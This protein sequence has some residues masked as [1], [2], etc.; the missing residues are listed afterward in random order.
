MGLI[1]PPEKCHIT[2]MPTTNVPSAYDSVEYTVNFNHSRFLFMFPSGHKNSDFVEKNKYVLRGLIMN[3]RFPY[4]PQKPYYD[5]DKLERI[6]NEAQVPTTPQSK[7]NNLILYLF[8]N[9]DYTGAPIMIN[10][11]ENV[12]PL[13]LD[14]LYFKNHKEYFFYL[15]TLK[16]RGYIEYIDT[17]NKNGPDAINIKLTY[18]GLEYIIQIQESGQNSRNCF[19]AMSFS[20]KTL[21]IRNA[22]KK[23][24]TE[25]GYEPILVDECFF[26]SEITINDAIIRFIKQCKFLIADFTEQKHGVYF[27]TG[28]AL[29]LKRQV[30]YTCSKADFEKCHFDTKHYP[31]I[32]YENTCELETKLKDKILAWIE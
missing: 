2:D 20:D 21:E 8:D 22:I 19:I 29:G 12:W 31:H 27:E 30:I 1:K 26:E 28:F 23:V 13:I 3:G 15:K 5:N 14:K 24:V 6:I 7:L 25:T 32:V 11:E 18:H 17:T 10:K 4:D 9:Q 16:E